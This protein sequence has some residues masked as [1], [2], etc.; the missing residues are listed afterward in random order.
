MLHR[1][2]ILGSGSL[3]RTLAIELALND[4]VGYR[5]I[6]AVNESRHTITN[7]IPCPCPSLGDISE[8]QSIIE[9][10]RVDR[11]ILA[12]DEN[13]EQIPTARLFEAQTNLHISIESGT[14]VLE[15]LTGKFPIDRFLGSYA[16]FSNAFRLRPLTTIACRLIS[17]ALS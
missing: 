9:Q 5:L 13:H 4:H 12:L 14:E 15:K 1:T 6:G 11:I 17:F 16:L 10:Q 7:D 2:I 8:L 3:A